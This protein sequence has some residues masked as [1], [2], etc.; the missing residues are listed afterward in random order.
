MLLQQRTILLTV[1]FTEGHFRQTQL[2]A[3]YPRPIF[4][5]VGFAKLDPLFNRES[6]NYQA[7]SLSSIGLD[8]SKR[9]FSTP[10]LFTPVL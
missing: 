2:Q 3:L 9:P 1:R 7:L 5:E 8:D 6:F 4:Q 10:P